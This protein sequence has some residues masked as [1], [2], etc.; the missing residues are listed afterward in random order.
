MSKYLPWVLAVLA[1]IIFVISLMI[2]DV[3]DA[4]EK[5]YSYRDFS[6]RSHLCT[7]WGLCI[8]DK[9]EDE[10]PTET[11]TTD[12]PVVKE[13]APM[14]PIT[15]VKP[16]PILKGNIGGNYEK[17]LEI[18]SKYSWN[19]EHAMKIMQCE[20]NYHP[21][22][23]NRN[24]ERSVGLFQINLHAHYHKVTGDNMHEKVLTLQN[25]HYNVSFAY[26]LYWRHGWLPWLNCAKKLKL[27]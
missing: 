12:A 24:G 1:F 19:K 17:A 22:A 4:G 13:I 26:T 16:K 20:S 23:E 3:A 2:K 14:R 6:W 8:R 21:F 25:R 10:L 27:I 11:Y 5:R 9:Y 7:F 15:P 18:V